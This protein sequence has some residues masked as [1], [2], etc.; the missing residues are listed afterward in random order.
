MQFP[1]KIIDL[2]QVLSSCAPSWDGGCGFLMTCNFNYNDC[3][4]VSFRAQRLEMSAGIGTHMDAPAHCVDNGVC[5]GNILLEGCIVSCVVIDVSE[6]IFS[7]RM[8]QIEDV[9]FFEKKHGTIA[10][11]CFVMIRTGWDAYWSN[12]IAYRN[13]MQFPTV[14]VDAAQLLLDRHVVGLG[15]D[16][17]SPDLP[18]SGYPVHAAFLGAGKYIVENIA[19]LEKMPPVGGY[20]VVLP[21]KILGGTES[22]IRLIGLIPHNEAI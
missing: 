12:P 6:N 4:S 18:D 9:M 22:P 14:S 17:L 16:T 5:T 8:L 3:H 20:S 13:N 10:P 15:V 2:S 19:H 7:K 11:N 21:L 1:F